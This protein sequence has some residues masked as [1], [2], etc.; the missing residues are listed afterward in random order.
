MQNITSIEGNLQIFRSLLTNLDDLQNLNFIGGKSIRIW[1]NNE[2]SSCSIE[3]ICNYLTNI[4]EDIKTVIRDNASGRKTVLE[5]TEQC[6]ERPVCPIL[7]NNTITI[8]QGQPI[9]LMDLVVGDQSGFWSGDGVISI[10][11][12]DGETQYY[13]S[14]YQTKPAKLYYTVKNSAC[15]QSLVLV[16]FDILSNTGSQSASYNETKKL[17]F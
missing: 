9:N 5:I 15:N 14:S 4:S 2:L 10:N 12:I 7:S 6:I 3:S 1:E 17:E 16:K 8:Q 13:F 11:T